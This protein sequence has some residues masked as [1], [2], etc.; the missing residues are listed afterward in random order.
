MS[1][2]GQ[3]IA[4]QVRAALREA[5]KHQQA[6]A[7]VAA[8]V[9]G[10]SHTVSVY[11]DEHVTIVQRDGKTHVVRHDDTADEPEQPGQEHEPPA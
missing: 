1:D 10:E 3:I 7:A 6:S 4:E 2:L 8:N 5:A 9:S 11:T